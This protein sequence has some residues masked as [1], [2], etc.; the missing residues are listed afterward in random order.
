MIDLLLPFLM[1]GIF[2]A[3]LLAN[4]L[5]RQHVVSLPAALVALGF[6]SSE[7]WVGLG[8]DTGLRWQILRDLVFFL[9]LPILVFEAAININVR[10]LKR[11]AVLIG[12]LSVPFLLIAASLAALLI[13]KVIGPSLSGSF[14][15]ALLI[16]A[17]ICA[18]DPTG[19]PEALGNQSE[20]LSLIH[21]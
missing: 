8:N 18:T 21:I 2:L 19:M 14:A 1:L 7:I 10:A 20:S 17:M 3:A 12:S 4:P 15:L 9:L 5:A 6:I 16:G 11:E 13:F